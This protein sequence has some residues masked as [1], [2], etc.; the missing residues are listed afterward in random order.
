MRSTFNS[1]LLLY[2]LHRSVC[3]CREK[4]LLQQF[5]GKTRDVCLSLKSLC[6]VQSD[7]GGNAEKKIAW[8]CYFICFKEV[9]NF[10]N[11][12]FKLPCFCFKKVSFFQKKKCTNTKAFWFSHETTTHG[13]FLTSCLFSVPCKVPMLY[14]Y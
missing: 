3:Y 4:S 5:P 8:N 6:Y 9:S 12:T 1:S 11:P 10:V 14:Y 13:C 2:K 7:K